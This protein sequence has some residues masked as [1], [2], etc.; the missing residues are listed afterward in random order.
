MFYHATQ[1]AIHLHHVTQI[2]LSMKLSIKPLSCALISGDDPNNWTL[3][4]FRLHTLIYPFAQYAGY[5]VPFHF[6]LPPDVS[7]FFL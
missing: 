4:D 6:E 3:L 7:N 2:N 5:P 1:E